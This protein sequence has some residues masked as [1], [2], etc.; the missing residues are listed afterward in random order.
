MDFEEEE[1]KKSESSSK[2]GYN[3]NKSVDHSEFDFGIDDEEEIF[4]DA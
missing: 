3:G 2:S 1:E 4:L